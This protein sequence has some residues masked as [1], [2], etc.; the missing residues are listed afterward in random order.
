[1]NV[2]LL[3]PHPFF[4]ER[5]T[6][7]A[8]DLLL[9]ALS[10]RGDRVDVITYHEGE[11]RS[12]PG[13]AIHRASP[14]FPVSNVR[15]GF[16][17]K[18]VYCDFFLFLKQLGMMRRARYD[19]VHAVEE[20]S[21]L[22]A[23]ASVLYRVPFVYDMDSMLSEQLVDKYSF[24]RHFGGMLRFLESIPMR[25]AIRVVPM[26]EALE[27]KAR[28][29]GARKTRVLTDVSL[30][31][32]GRRSVPAESLREGL[33]IE[34][35]IVMYVGNLESYQGVPLLLD[36]FRASRAEERGVHLVAVG[37]A[38][39]Q[40]E[41]YRRRCRKNGP[42]GRVHFIGSR[43][44]SQL[45]ALLAQADIVASPRIAGENTPMKI[46]SYLDSGKPVIATRLRTHTQVIEDG[47]ALLVEP[48][49]ES[50]AS[51]LNLLYD[52]A[53]LRRS[54]AGRARE[55]VAARYTLDHYRTNVKALYSEIE[56]ERKAGS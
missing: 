38:P 41:R 25:K 35:M 4:Q 8:V 49:V 30:I 44:S 7:I 42:E 19:V 14:L 53:D 21:F 1:M 34:G 18:K 9:Q 23:I 26:C 17:F 27:E 20:A 5:G 11:N 47:M 50:F 28:R 12:Y 2:L 15:P 6:P 48:D 43:P 51:G 3:A 16:S 29:L 32:G 33:G 39:A 37:G 22:A 52:D 31:D 13:V 40:V 56:Q 36:A 24:L 46:Y 54:L 55:V 10:E 45:G